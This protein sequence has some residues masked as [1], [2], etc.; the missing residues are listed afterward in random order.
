[1]ATGLA[2]RRRHA[3]RVQGQLA[4]R[5]R[6]W[7]ERFPATILLTV[8]YGAFVVRP[9]VQHHTAP[10]HL[11]VGICLVAVLVAFS[12]EATL[13]WIG[14]SR[15]RPTTVTPQAA[16]I[17]F[18]IGVVATLGTALSGRGSYAVQIGTASASRF[19]SLFTPFVSWLLFGVL[20]VLYLYRQRL[21]SRR[22]AS[23][24]VFL[25]FSIETLVSLRQALFAPLISFA[26]PV[27]VGLLLVRMIR[28]RWIVIAAFLLPI[29]LP[30]LYSLRNGLRVQAG[31]VQGFSGTQTIATRLRLDLDMGQ[32]RNFAVV[33]AKIG[34]PSF[35]TLVRFGLLPRIFDPQRPNLSTAEQLSVA[36]GGSSVSSAS[37]T[38]LGEAYVLSSWAGIVGLV[39]LTTL[40]I[41]IGVRM[42]SGWWFV[43]LGVAFSGVSALASY[44][45]LLASA[46]QS[47][48]SICGAM[49]ACWIVRTARSPASR[50]LVA[51]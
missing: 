48:E 43:F 8:Q 11:I 18:F 44:P 21:V 16:T 14:P 3:S 33:P 36:I 26:L 25:G 19:A 38:P 7:L 30:P 13:V 40:A 20:L 32:L 29:A 4:S 9:A 23:M 34:Q 2:L 10:E 27:L 12:I 31:G 42:Q 39:A 41:A 46:L 6:L 45:S 1:M 17:V 22:R 24:I 37:L 50:R 5:R 35:G 28:I 49:I 47:I 51:A 15:T